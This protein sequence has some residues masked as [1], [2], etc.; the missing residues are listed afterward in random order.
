MIVTLN[1]T[2]LTLSLSKGVDKTGFDRLSLSA[3]GAE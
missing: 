2:A 1:Q 3:G